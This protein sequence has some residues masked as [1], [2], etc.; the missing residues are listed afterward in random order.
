VKLPPDVRSAVLVR[1][2]PMEAGGRVLARRDKDCAFQ[3]TT[4]PKPISLKWKYFQNYYLSGKFKRINLE[5]RFI[6]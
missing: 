3:V 4:H 1:P 2:K 6:D 5:Y